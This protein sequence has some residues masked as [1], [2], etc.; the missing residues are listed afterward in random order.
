MYDHIDPSLALEPLDVLMSSG[1]AQ[2]LDPAEEREMLF[3]RALLKYSS[4]H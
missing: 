2:T 1:R 4:A 3:K